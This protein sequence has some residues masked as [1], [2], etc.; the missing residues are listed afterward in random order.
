[1]MSNDS[2]LLLDDRTVLHTVEAKV[3]KS[4]EAGLVETPEIYVPHHHLLFFC[5]TL[6]ELSPETDL[7]PRCHK[8]G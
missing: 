1:M 3:L 6:R 7:A 2:L 4:D 5:W 8:A